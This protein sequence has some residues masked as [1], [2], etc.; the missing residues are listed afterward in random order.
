M[1]DSPGFLRFV[2]SLWWWIHSVPFTAVRRAFTCLIFNSSKNMGIIKE[3]WLHSYLEPPSKIRQIPCKVTRL[4]LLCRK[5]L[6]N[7]GKRS[8]QKQ[9]RAISNSFIFS[10]QALANVVHTGRPDATRRFCLSRFKG[11]Y[12]SK[13][14]CAVV[15]DLEDAYNRVTLKSLIVRL[16]ALQ[17]CPFHC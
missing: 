1:F 8:L 15:K 6:E 11:F 3:E 7:C 5:W 12:S 9:F 17:F 14:A 16:L 4:P 13:E 10:N 2:I